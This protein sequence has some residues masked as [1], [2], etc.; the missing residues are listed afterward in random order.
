MLNLTKKEVIMIGD[1]E[2]KDIQGANSIG[3]KS[4]KIIL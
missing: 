4:Y 1:S 2:D 3:I